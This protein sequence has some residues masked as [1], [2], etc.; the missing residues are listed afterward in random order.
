[1]PS[2]LFEASRVD[3]VYGPNVDAY[4]TIGRIDRDIG[5]NTR[6]DHIVI[7]C[8]GTAATCLVERCARRG[9]HA[10]DLG[11]VGRWIRRWRKQ[12]QALK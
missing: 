7:L 11:S 10:V 1:M 2:D 4:A 8:L 12:Q 6:L 3:V 5:T 9:V